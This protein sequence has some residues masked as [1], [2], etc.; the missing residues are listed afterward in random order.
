MAFLTMIIGLVGKP[1]AGKS[2]F[3][4]AATLAEVEIANYPFTTI[5]PNTGIGYV[6]VECAETFF[7]TKCNPR[8]GYC[9][10]GIRFVPF[11]LIDVAGL[12][13]D[14]HLGKGR[15]NQFLDDLRQADALIHVVDMS[16]STNAHGE[17]VAAGSHDPLEDITFLE[18]EIDLWYL[19]IL[20]K[21]WERFARTV[22]QSKQKIAKAITDQLSA[23]KVTEPMTED[24]MKKM[25]LNTENITFW[26]AEDLRKLTTELRKATKPIVIAANKMDVSV[27]QA[28]L[29]R[30]KRQFPN[31]TIIPCSAE[32]ELALREA[33]K[34]GMIDYVPGEKDYSLKNEAALNEN[35]KKA[36]EFIRKNVLRKNDGSGVQ[37]VL[38][39]AV[40]EL[41]R[42]IPIFPGGMN[43]LGDQYGNILPDCFLLPPNSTAYDF[44][45]TIH[46]DLAKGFIRAID[47]KK[48][49]IVGRDY[50]LKYGDVIEIISSK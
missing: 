30:A 41:L 36:L 49:Q 1:S 34:K 38:N 50:T 8:T 37:Q 3:F 45:N 46:S 9:L 48:R 47:V 12:V 31:L 16:G 6:K 2:T 17:P 39:H 27:S 11:Q 25:N 32:S 29:E 13:P 4:K 5:K 19:G 18:V 35:Q 43:K 23:F 21:G 20:N 44:A 26:T 42:Y 28:N 22:F 15:G 24:I 7:K 10:N 40:F 14:A 33:A